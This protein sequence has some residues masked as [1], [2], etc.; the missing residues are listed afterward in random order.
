M[1]ETALDRPFALSRV[2]GDLELLKEIAAIFLEDSPKIL[3]EIRGALEKKDAQAVERAAHNLKGSVANFG[4]R[5]TVEAALR[6]EQIGRSGQ[7][8]H[9]TEALQVLEQVLSV[10]RRELEAL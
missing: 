8:E 5:S 1:P 7:L 3:G 6:L 4:A 10:L 2:G 9:A